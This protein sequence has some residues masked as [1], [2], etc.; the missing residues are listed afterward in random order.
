MKI[1]LITIMF[2]HCSVQFI[3]ILWFKI[4]CLFMLFYYLLFVILFFVFCL[5]SVLRAWANM[6]MYRLYLGW[7]GLY[8]V[9]FAYALFCV[10]CGS[11]SGSLSGF[12]RS[13]C[14]CARVIYGVNG[15]VIW[16]YYVCIWFHR[17]RVYA[18]LD[19]CIIVLYNNTI[20]A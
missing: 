5:C 4:K 13:I 12:H 14:I 15:F 17:R 19:T 7:Y 8:V 6:V 3:F 11:V 10:V 16:C 1:I 20:L 2:R 18:N 9:V